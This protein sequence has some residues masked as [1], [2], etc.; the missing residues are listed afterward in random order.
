MSQQD[1]NVLEEIKKDRVFIVSLIEQDKNLQKK[2]KDQDVKIQVPQKSEAR[3]LVAVPASDI[4]TSYYNQID[5]MIN[6]LEKFTPDQ[7]KSLDNNLTY[8]TWAT[9]ILPLVLTAISGGIFVVSNSLLSFLTNA[10]SVIPPLFINSFK[11]KLDTYNKETQIKAK[12]TSM[13]F[14]IERLVSQDKLTDENQKMIDDN[15][16]SIADEIAKP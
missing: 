8:A 11:G 10:F 2:L 5:G 16:K 13:K 14:Q 15:L 7:K 3:G 4:A 9:A 12:L 6:D 1:K